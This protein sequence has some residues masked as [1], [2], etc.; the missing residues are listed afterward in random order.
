MVDYWRAQG[1]DIRATDEDIQDIQKYLI[2]M[3][4]V[5]KVTT[6]VGQ[7]AL[8][9]MLVYAPETTNASYA[10]FLVEVEDYRTIDVLSVQAKQYILHNFQNSEPKIRKIALG[11]RWWCKD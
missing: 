1:T 10:Q 9:F 6:L 8:R 5:T 4:G 3:E 7:G 2:G 11:P